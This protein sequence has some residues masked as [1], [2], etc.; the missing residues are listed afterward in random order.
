MCVSVEMPS[1]FFAENCSSN[2]RE[3]V[4]SEKMRPRTAARILQEGLVAISIG[5]TLQTTRSQL[6]FKAAQV[7]LNY[8]SFAFPARL[9]GRCHGKRE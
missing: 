7:I 8:R 1:K 4:H 6:A 9:A 3:R 2:A 5:D